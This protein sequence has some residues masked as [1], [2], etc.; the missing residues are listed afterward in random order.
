MRSGPSTN[1]S[2]IT[3]L[4]PGTT[5][6]VIGRN[7]DESWFQLRLDDGTEGW[8]SGTLLRIAPASTDGAARPKPAPLARRSADRPPRQVIDVTDI[9]PTATATAAATDTPPGTPPDDTD[10]PAAATNTPRAT[11]TPEATLT[12]SVPATRGPSPTPLA[13]PIATLANRE[14]RW[15][16]TT[17]G[18]IVAATII[19]VGTL[20]N[21]IR[22]FTRRRGR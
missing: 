17:L 2:V 19:T 1:F 20:I 8:V 22:S 14:E 5:A 4:R 9:P 7:D 13:P 10:Q 11:A 15:Y 18:V 3:S 12:P 21:I 16:A 6:E